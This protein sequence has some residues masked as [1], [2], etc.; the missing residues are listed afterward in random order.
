MLAASRHRKS[1]SPRHL[2]EGETA[3][4]A[5]MVRGT[6]AEDR[7]LAQISDALV[8]DLADG[9]MGSIRFR[10]HQQD[11]RAFGR[12][13]GEATFVDEDGIVVSATLNLDQ[14]GDLFELDLWKVD[15]SPLRKY[16]KPDDIVVVDRAR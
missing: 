3:L 14:H 15:N 1:A 16:P 10:G 6:T 5:A 2:R 9:G 8:E 12:Q 7:V 11:K 4:V 13:I